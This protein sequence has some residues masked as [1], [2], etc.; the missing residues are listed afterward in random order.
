[1]NKTRKICI[2]TGSRAEY[3]LLFWL[4]K[5]IEAAN[6]L[7]L[8]LIVTGMHL[9]PE[10]G[11]TVKHIEQDGFTISRKVEMLLSSDSTVGITKSMGLG[12]IGFADALSGLTPDL[13]VILGDRFEIFS[14]A[15]AAMI[16]KIPVAHL[17][18]GEVTEGAFD[19]SIR[20]SI[21][22]MSHLHF[23]ATEEYR[24]RVI[25][26]GE[27]PERVFCVGAPGIDNIKRL[28]LLSRNKLEESINF[29]LGKHN[30][31][32][33]FHPVTLENSTAEEQFRNLLR[34][35]DELEETHLL[36]TRT[37]ADTGGRVINKLIDDYVATRP[38]KAVAFTSLGQLRYF[39]AMQYMDAVIG[40]SSSGLI[41]APTFKIATV[42]IGD[43]QRGRIRSESVIDCRPDYGSIRKAIR[44]IYNPDFLKKLQT[45]SNPY[46][47]GGASAKITEIIRNHPLD[48][49]L[50]K[51]FFDI[52]E[53]G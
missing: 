5:E 9:S 11:L 6:D 45:L 14:A 37:N 47:S 48:N 39:S 35:L 1:M 34:A 53:K 13:M 12:I 25:Q 28:P 52:E 19:E 3:G 46:G 20:H 33:T 4:M 15:S 23:T 43:R 26:L 31:L 50:K 40:N 36:F 8:Q 22:R 41:E 44:K 24:N 21:T 2:V 18:G 27:Q 7:Q 49:I 17:H 16:A 51:R 30:F 38:D 29:K 32:V 10:F 42:N